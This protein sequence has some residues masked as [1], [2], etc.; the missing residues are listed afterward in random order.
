[1]TAIPRQ[2]PLRGSIPFWI[3]AV[4]VLAAI[5]G[6][7]PIAAAIFGAGG[8]AAMRT[9]FAAAP[10]GA[11]AVV[12]QTEM[13]EDVLR[14][15]PAAGGAPIEVA[16]V[17]HLPGFATVGKVSPDGARVAVV[18]PDAGS[19][20]RPVASLAVIDLATGDVTRVAA[21]VDAEMAPVWTPDGSAVVYTR[22]APSATGA[23]EVVV[24]AAPATSGAERELGRVSGVLGAYPV[25]FVAGDL[26]TV[27]IDGQGS[28]VLRG[29][30]DLGVISPNITRDWQ[31]SPD[32][33]RLAFIEADLSAGLHYRA[34]TVALTLSDEIEVAAQAYVPGV[35]QQ[36]GVAW[37]P[38]AATPTFGEDPQPPGVE[39]M[40]QSASSG[41]DLPL[42]YSPD[43]ASLVVQSWSG[44]SFANPGEMQLALV[45]EHGR[46][47]LSGATRFF[48]WAAR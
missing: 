4:S 20:T 21:Q 16:R 10:P 46:T 28:S 45:N 22:T 18:S 48:G 40:A 5:A 1:M 23:A 34:R 25:G 3:I 30:N 24:L 14:V 41:F 15:V 17:P 19:L 27:V 29:G 6:V 9:A 39:A 37:R 8:P 47:E 7:L 35:G 36:L 32:G 33:T 12:V 13:A 31:L 2:S 44:T 26:I 38:G 42:A 43:G 11:Y